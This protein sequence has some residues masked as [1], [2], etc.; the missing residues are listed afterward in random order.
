MLVDYEGIIRKLD[1]KNQELAKLAIDGAMGIEGGSS[2]ESKFFAVYLVKILDASLVFET[3]FNAGGMAYAICSN[4]K[5][6]GRYVGFE[7]N[8]KVNPIVEIIQA[9]F[10]EKCSI[11]YGDSKETLKQFVGKDKCDIFIVDGDHSREGLISDLKHALVCTRVGGFILVDDAY[12]LANYIYEL[13]PR[14]RVQFISP[15]S[16]LSNGLAVIQ[17]I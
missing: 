16:N 14:D 15:P 10:P 11:V 1:S 2:P 8:Q 4:L 9:E 13:V 17:V 6:G 12:Y 7:I 3:G 5:N